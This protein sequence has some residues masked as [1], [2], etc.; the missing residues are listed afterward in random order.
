MCNAYKM[1][2][3]QREGYVWFLPGW[4]GD[5]WYD[6]DKLKKGK[7]EIR[8]QNI[9]DSKLQ[10]SINMYETSEVGILPNCST[11]E[12]LIALNGHLSLMHA[13]LAQDEKT[14]P[15]GRTVGQWKR[16]FKTHLKGK[17]FNYWAKKGQDLGTEPYMTDDFQEIKPDRNCGY[18]YDAVLLYA[19]ALHELVSQR[20]MSYLQ[21]LHSERTVNAFVKIINKT[22]FHGVSG[23][24]NFKGRPSRLSNIRI[25]QCR[26]DDNESRLIKYEVGVYEPN[27][28]L[29][30]MDIET[31]DDLVGRMITWNDTNLQWQTQDGVKPLDNPIECGILSSFATYLDI[32]CQLAIT[33]TF[34]IALGIVL[35]ILLIF[36]LLQKR[37]YSDIILYYS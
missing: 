12:M 17:Y 16:D 11:K 29:E 21:N 10:K 32:K 30:S 34:L 20:N 35:F 2:M 9:S 27:Y 3:T 33:F 4:F 24:I 23:R 6:I 36:F 18:V 25:I 1:G 37:R 5:D 15:D 31:D 22:D 13:S 8:S 19:K 28:D 26:K 7:S 14:I